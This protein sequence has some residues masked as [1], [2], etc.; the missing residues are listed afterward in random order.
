MK[1]TL[2]KGLGLFSVVHFGYFI[3]DWV[4]LEKPASTIIIIALVI[5]YFKL[6][7]MLVFK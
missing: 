7:E 3:V 5:L 4:S 2:I 1:V 6:I